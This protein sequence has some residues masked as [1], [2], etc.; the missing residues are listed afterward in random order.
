MVLL[1]GIINIGIIINNGIISGFSSDT[2][3]NSGNGINTTDIGKIINNR[4]I[5]G[6]NQAIKGA[7]TSLT[8]NGIIVGYKN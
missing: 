5:K 4:V 3:N 2:D 6:S 1:Q 7:Q 8:N